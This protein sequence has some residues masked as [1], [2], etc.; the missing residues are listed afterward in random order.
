MKTRL[1]LIVIILLMAIQSV[2]AV[3]T[4][5]LQCVLTEKYGMYEK[6]E[7]DTDGYTSYIWETSLN[8][9]SKGM[10]ETISKYVGDLP[11]N[12]VIGRY[13][14]DAIPAVA[15]I[16]EWESQTIYVSM[17]KVY[18]KLEVDGTNFEVMSLSVII[19]NKNGKLNSKNQHTVQERL[20]P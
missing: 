8:D 3:N 20:R 19:K 15:D 4:K 11:Y 13:Y 10:I 18:G 17:V 16:V 5:P 2:D 6:A 9:F 7:T 1:Y 12:K 14:G